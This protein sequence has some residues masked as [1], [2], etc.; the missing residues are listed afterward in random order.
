MSTV[1]EIAEG[2]RRTTDSLNFLSSSSSPYLS[3]EATYETIKGMQTPGQGVQACV[4]HQ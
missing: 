4:K 2:E 3:G 1:I